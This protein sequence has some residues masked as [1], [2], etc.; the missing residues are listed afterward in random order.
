MDETTREADRKPLYRA[1]TVRH[2]QR[3]GSIYFEEYGNTR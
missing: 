3:Q 2:V 1:A